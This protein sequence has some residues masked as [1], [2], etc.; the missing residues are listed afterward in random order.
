MR[1]HNTNC[2]ATDTVVKEGKVFENSIAGSLWMVKEV[3]SY[4]KC[5][6]GHVYNLV[7]QD[8][9]PYRK[10]GRLLRFIPLEIYDWVY[11]GGK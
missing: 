4:L 3:A 2:Q 11:E 8:K 1:N 5:S 6:V 7:Y 10:R 9:I